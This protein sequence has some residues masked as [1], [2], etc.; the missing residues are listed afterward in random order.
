MRFQVTTLCRARIEAACDALRPIV[1]TEAEESDE[2]HA[3]IAVG[4]A[5]FE[6]YLALQQMAG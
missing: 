4:T 3:A 1:F 2:E 6:I 5:L